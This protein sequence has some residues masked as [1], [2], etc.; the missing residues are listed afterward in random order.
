MRTFLISV[1]AAVGFCMFAPDSPAQDCSCY[2]LSFAQVHCLNCNRSVEVG[3]CSG[4]PNNCQ[5]CKEFWYQIY[6]CPNEYA[7]SA[8]SN[9]VC[10]S[11]GGGLGPSQLAS[12]LEG[13]IPARILLP[14]CTGTYVSVR[15]PSTQIR[16][17]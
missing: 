5:N 4:F 2:F 13:A 11:G 16:N 17:Q 14:T 3:Q 7:G 1:V 12:K 9:G 6:C 8:T 15:L 10:T